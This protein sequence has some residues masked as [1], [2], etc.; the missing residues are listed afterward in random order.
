MQVSYP[1]VGPEWGGEGG[2]WLAVLLGLGM[3]RPHLDTRRIVGTAGGAPGSEWGGAGRDRDGA[4]R[5][6]DG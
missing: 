3:A 4:L 5:W 6:G 2:S 1:G